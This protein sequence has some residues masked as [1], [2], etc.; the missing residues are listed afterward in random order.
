MSSVLFQLHLKGV[1]AAAYYQVPISCFI[2]ALP[3]L[4]I[5][6]RCRGPPSVIGGSRLELRHVQAV[7]SEGAHPALS[8]EQGNHEVHR[9]K[10]QWGVRRRPQQ[11]GRHRFPPNLIRGEKEEKKTTE[12]AA[13]TSA[14]NA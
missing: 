11:Q 7:R 2:G 3:T 10:E 5:L 4:K 13:T 14:T 1:V 12:M 8:F 9:V 6:R